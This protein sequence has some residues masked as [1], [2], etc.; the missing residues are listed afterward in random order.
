MSQKT[1]W[2]GIFVAF[3]LFVTG[4]VCMMPKANAVNKRPCIGTGEFNRA[5]LGTSKR[6]LEREME[7]VGKGIDASLFFPNTLLYPRCGSPTLE[8]GYYGLVFAPM[9]G[10]WMKIQCKS[11]SSEYCYIPQAILAK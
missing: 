6:K 7:V 3:C 5:E 4:L 8:D 10:L 2:T 9:Q 1:Y 11:V